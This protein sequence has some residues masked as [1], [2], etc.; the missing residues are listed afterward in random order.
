LQKYIKAIEAN[1]NTSRKRIKGEIFL[2]F[3]RLGY[4]E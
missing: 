3:W 4:R 2:D 1:G